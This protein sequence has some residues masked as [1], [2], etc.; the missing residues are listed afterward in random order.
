M[1]QDAANEEYRHNQLFELLR[2]T[3]QA[4]TTVLTTKGYRIRKVSEDEIRMLQAAA[5]RSLQAN[6]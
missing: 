5:L 1:H 4:K 3:N 2:Q 6:H